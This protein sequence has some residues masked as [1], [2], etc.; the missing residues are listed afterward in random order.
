VGKFDHGHDRIATIFRLITEQYIGG[1]QL[2]QKR[3]KM[4]KMSCHDVKDDAHTPYIRHLRNVRLSEQYLWCCIGV[5]ATVS[6]T[7]LE[8]AV[9]R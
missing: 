3:A 7:T 4:I 6:L 2:R 5:T 9:H 8:L 1:I